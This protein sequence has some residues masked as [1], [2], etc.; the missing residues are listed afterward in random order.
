MSELVDKAVAALSERLNGTLPGSAKFVLTG[1]GAIVIDG[2]GVRAG[3]ETTDVTL[4]ADPVVFQSILK[5]DTN[6]ATAFMT[7]QLSVDGDMGIAMQLANIL[8]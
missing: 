2:S 4:T 6:P 1:E 7:G 8:S 3:D 5:G